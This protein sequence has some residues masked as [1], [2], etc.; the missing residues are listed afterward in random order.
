MKKEKQIRKEILYPYKTDRFNALI[1]NYVYKHIVYILLLKKFYN[2]NK[3]EI[4]EELKKRNYFNV[5]NTIE[6]FHKDTFYQ[7]QIKEILI[8]YYMF[9]TNETD[10]LELDKFYF[11]SYANLVE[12]IPIKIPISEWNYKNITQ[13]KSEYLTKDNVRDIKELLK[14]KLNNLPEPKTLPEFEQNDIDI[15]YDNYLIEITTKN[16]INFVPS[17][18]KLKELNFEKDKKG[19]II[20][21]RFE[22]LEIINLNG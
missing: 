13:I 4:F 11:L 17:T 21:P 9:I 6:E 3:F 14:F 12:K 18:K 5:F 15:Y 2:N 1:N 8:F 20:N 10:N 22:L 19:I 7:D 16:T